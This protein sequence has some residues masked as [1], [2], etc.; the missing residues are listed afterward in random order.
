MYEHYSQRKNTSDSS[1]LASKTRRLKWFDHVSRMGQ[2]RLPKALSQWRPENAKRRRE[3]CRT[4]W[5][6]AVECEARLA[7]IDQDLEP[8]TVTGHTRTIGVLMPCCDDD[9]D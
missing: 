9:D 7:G 1:V 6:D 5:R 2:E 4:R 8:G 3:R